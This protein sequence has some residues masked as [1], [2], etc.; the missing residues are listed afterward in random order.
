MEALSAAA[1]GLVGMF[2]VVLVSKVH[3]EDRECANNCTM[4]WE[5]NGYRMKIN[6]PMSNKHFYIED[7]LD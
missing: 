3:M 2:M 5:S 4:E 7:F 1:L 6:L